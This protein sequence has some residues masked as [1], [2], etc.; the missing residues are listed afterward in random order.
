[1]K[2]TIAAIAAAALLAPVFAAAAGPS[3]RVLESTKTLLKPEIL[4]LSKEDGED[5]SL[6][7]ETQGRAQEELS[8][9]CRGKERL[10]LTFDGGDVSY[11]RCDGRLHVAYRGKADGEGSVSFSVTGDRRVSVSSLLKL[12]RLEADGTVGRLVDKEK[13]NVKVLPKE[14]E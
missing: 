12:Y 8:F 5:A 3:I 2:K 10:G 4:D 7:W 11:I 1:M 9:R 14:E 13:K 6:S